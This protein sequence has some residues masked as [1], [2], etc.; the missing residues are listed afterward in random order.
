MFIVAWVSN[1]SQLLFPLCRCARL[2]CRAPVPSL[3]EL[4]ENE[5]FL[6]LVQHIVVPSICILIKFQRS[7][8][9]WWRTNDSRHIR[10]IW[11]VTHQGV[12]PHRKRD[13]KKWSCSE[14]VNYDMKL[15]FLDRLHI[16]QLLCS[17]LAK[18]DALKKR[19]CMQDAFLLLF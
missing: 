5:E 17:L 2:S 12:T 6:F 19:M 10:A 13:F 7:T 11:Q 9:P 3:L 8:T 15:T 1:G 18:G 16:I 14:S 4:N